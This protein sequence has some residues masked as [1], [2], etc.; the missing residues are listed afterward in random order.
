[1]DL[2]TRTVTFSPQAYRIH[3]LAPGTPID[4]DTAMG[5]YPQAARHALE[6]TVAA[7]IARGTTWDLQ[8]P[9]V[10]AAG[11]SRW[12]R[13]AGEVEYKDGAPFQIVGTILDITAEHEAN[14]LIREKE[15]QYRLLAENA[16][17]MIVRVKLDG[18]R[19]YVSPASRDLIGFDPEDLVGTP[20]KSRAIV[21]P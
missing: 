1:M 17:D 8:L 18:T 2:E 10:T 16:S 20:V 21:T 4:H 19:V 5:F 6:A 11:R 15:E 7:A 3:D 13:T 12:I 9:F 14:R